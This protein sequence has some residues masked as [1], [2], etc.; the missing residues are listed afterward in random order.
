MHI[1]ANRPR[2]GTKRPS[3]RNTKQ[4]DAVFTRRRTYSV[5]APMRRPAVALAAAMLSTVLIGVAPCPTHASPSNPIS[6]HAV[7]SGW[8]TSSG[9]HSP[10][11]KNYLTGDV[12]FNEYR[13]YFAFD[14]AGFPVVSGQTVT[15]ATLTLDTVTSHS[16]QGREEVS[17]FDVDANLHALATTTSSLDT[18]IDLGTGVVLGRRTYLREEAY[19]QKSI[20]LNAAG[21]AAILAAA[22]GEFALGAAVTSIDEPAATGDSSTWES[23]FGDSY[24]AMVRRLDVWVV[25]SRAVD[26]RPACRPARAYRRP[27]PPPRP[28]ARRRF[29][30]RFPAALRPRAQ[31]AQ[32]CFGADASLVRWPENGQTFLLK[33]GQTFC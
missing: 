25:H 13:S 12:A 16:A 6:F 11:T 15:R 7:D 2:R 30:R 31:Q 19:T 18:F 21:L 8:Y 1:A 28:L 24:S 32:T 20:E 4:A 17:L 23:L 9:N 27:A 22:P 14:L 33:L 26:G 10:L 5:G 29:R 3:F